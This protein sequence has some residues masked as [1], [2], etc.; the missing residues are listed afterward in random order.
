M[1]DG[2]IGI[3]PRSRDFCQLRAAS[4]LDAVW[5]RFAVLNAIAKILVYFSPQRFRGFLK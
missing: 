2:G 3:A 1:D 5:S 4:G